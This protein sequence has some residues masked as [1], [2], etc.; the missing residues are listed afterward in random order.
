MINNRPLAFVLT[1]YLLSGCANLH[2][3]QIGEIDNRRGLKRERFE[4]KV[5][6]TGIN[7]DEAA[8]IAKT[9]ASKSDNENIE[10][11]RG[12]VALFQQ[13]P[14]TGN[15]IYFSEYAR[16]F[17]KEI[18]Q[19]CPRGLISGLNSIR[20]TRKYPV[21]SGEIIKITGYCLTKS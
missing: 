1:T 7:L 9:F 2:H 8:D 3:I 5:S 6:E 10:A 15:P 20:E 13:G 18:Y 14:R 4:L 12:F 16:N 21:I 17:Y 11:I 19:A